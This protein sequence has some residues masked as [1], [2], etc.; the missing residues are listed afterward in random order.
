MSASQRRHLRVRQSR[1]ASAKLTPSS[2]RPWFRQGLS[3]LDELVARPCAD[4]H[5]LRTLS[6]VL[7]L[8]THLHVLRVACWTDHTLSPE[9][10]WHPCPWHGRGFCRAR[11]ASSLE[12]LPRRSVSQTVICTF[13]RA[14]LGS[15]SRDRALWSLRSGSRPLRHP[16]LAREC[17]GDC[18]LRVLLRHPGHDSRC[19]SPQLSLLRL[20]VCLVVSGYF[21]TQ[22]CLH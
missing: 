18:A 8:S 5:V 6:H 9:I 21:S 10:G 2:A 17:R 16:A 3:C 4:P 13:H 20:A 7:L 22:T 15:V 19:D 11:N 14:L 12:P 1:S